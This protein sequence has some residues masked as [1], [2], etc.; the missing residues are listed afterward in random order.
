MQ[1]NLKRHMIV[2]SNGNLSDTGPRIYSN[3][4]KLDVLKKVQEFGI[5]ATAKLVKYHTHFLSLVHLTIDLKG[6]DSVQHDQQLGESCQRGTQLSFL[7]KD[8]SMEGS[9]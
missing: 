1:K 3:D 4:F 6:Q 7:W 9:T 8:I 5:S 2:H